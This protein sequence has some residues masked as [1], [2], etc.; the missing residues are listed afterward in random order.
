MEAMQRTGRYAEQG[1]TMHSYTAKQIATN[2]QI[3][4]H[5]DFHMLSSEIVDRILIAAKA[6]GYRKPKSANGSPARY[7]YALLCR[8]ALRAER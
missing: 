3:P 8:A 1:F 2:N 4:L 7:F 6:Y 5:A